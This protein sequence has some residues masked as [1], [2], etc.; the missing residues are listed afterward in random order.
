MEQLETIAILDTGDREYVRAAQL[1][2]QADHRRDSN[3]LLRPPVD[4][5]DVQDALSVL[6]EHLG[7]DI[8]RHLADGGQMRLD[9]AIALAMGAE[10]PQPYGADL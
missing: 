4:E 8:E 7:T 9:D 3:S 6:R 2:G 5:R 1:I 10:A